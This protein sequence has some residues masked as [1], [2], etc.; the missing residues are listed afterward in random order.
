MGRTFEVVADLYVQAETEEDAVAVAEAFL[1][2]PRGKAVEALEGFC[3]AGCIGDGCEG[4][5][6]CGVYGALSI[7]R[8]S[9]DRG[10]ILRAELPPRG[11]AQMED[12]VLEVEGTAV[13]GTE[14]A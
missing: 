13:P 9:S 3:R 11:Y 5:G 4:Q 12:T 14:Q 2:A 7:L 1:E 10:K 8:A 6:C